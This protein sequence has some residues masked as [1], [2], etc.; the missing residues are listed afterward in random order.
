MTLQELVDTIEEPFT[1][2]VS[3]STLD[4]YDDNFEPLEFNGYLSNLP[5]VFLLKEIY[6]INKVD[7][8]NGYIDVIL[9]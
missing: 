8:R 7:A 3:C 5:S 6:T 9:E 1:I 4:D 2:K